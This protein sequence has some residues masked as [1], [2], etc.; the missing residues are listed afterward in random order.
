MRTLLTSLLL[1]ASGWSSAQVLTA[2]EAV[3]IAVEQNHGIR[4]ARLDARS[5]ELLNNP[6]NAGMLPTVDAVGQY[7]IDNSATK[8]TFFS[9]D[10][11]ETD[12]ADQRVLDAAVQLNWTVFDGLA[13]FAAKDRLEA[14]ELIGQTRLRQQMEATTYDVLAAYYQL[15]QLRK[16]IAVQ[17][18]GVRISRERLRITE[19][20][21]RIGSASGL[22]M[23]QARL[24]LSTDSALVLDLQLQVALTTT[25][26]NA[27]MGRDPSTQLEVASEVPA[28]ETLDLA[29]VQQAARQA[30]STVQQ[31]RQQQI[32][33]DLSMKELRGTLLPQVDLFSN[34]GYT[35]S[36]SAVGI[37][38]S[39]Q[40]LGPDYGARVSIPLFRGLQMRSAMEVA[41]LG[42]EQASIITQQAELDLEESVLNAW[43]AYT[44]S[45]QRVALEE[46]NLNSSRTQVDI[47]L[48]SFRLG[49]ITSVE[50]RDV[51]QGLV[52]AEGR[53]L[54]A[55]YEAKVAELHLK[56]LAGRLL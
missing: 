42:Q 27:L 12:N 52:A 23:V 37:L 49:A 39:N 18:E 48:E 56:W 26:L 21:A 9:G 43:T 31:A 30:N 38:Q 19:T 41:K 40:A 36:T 20:G 33:A 45:A 47:A 55:R 46:A 11:R 53:S 32:A 51:Q 22:N 15:V 34:Y 17:Q 5:G 8:Q 4:I 25:R 14:L 44:L 50:L 54:A 13:M 16:A 35:R 10:V 6:G 1:L 3:R 7:S 24:D 2:E 28:A 29:Q